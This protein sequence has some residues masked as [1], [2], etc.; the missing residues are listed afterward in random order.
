MNRRPVS[1]RQCQ[2][3][4]RQNQVA[5]PP[6][7]A[8]GKTK[9]T[10]GKKTNAFDGRCGQTC[11]ILTSSRQHS[12]PACSKADFTVIK[13]FAAV[14]SAQKKWSKLKSPEAMPIYVTEES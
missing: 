14:T 10:A 5:L 1:Q 2:I 6:C 4:G 3:G 13:L 8:E 9:R 12:R 11:L 7:S